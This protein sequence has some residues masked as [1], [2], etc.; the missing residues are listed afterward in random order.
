MSIALALVGAAAASVLVGVRFDFAD[1]WVPSVATS[2]LFVALTIT[3]IDR[4]IRAEGQRRR[5]PLRQRALWEL[6]GEWRTLCTCIAQD[7]ADAHSVEA[8]SLPDNTFAVLQMWLDDHDPEDEPRRV[9]ADGLPALV[10]AAVAFAACLREI[11]A[12]AGDVL[13][14]ELALEI[15]VFAKDIDSVRRAFT[16]APE[17]PVAFL[18]AVVE[19]AVEGVLRVGQ[20]LRQALRDDRWFSWPTTMIGY[21]V[22][23]DAWL[24]RRSS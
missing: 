9:G 7:Y 15:E 18:G 16:D 10:R 4:A 17:P 11:R 19:V 24:D 14:P 3:V 6:I 13:E 5:E 20:A 12:R 1:A 8:S 23:R 22:T 2:A 21:G